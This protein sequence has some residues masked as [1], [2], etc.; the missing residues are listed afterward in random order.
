MAAVIRH[1]AASGHQLAGAG[2]VVG[3]L[4]EPE[5]IANDHIRIHAL[6][7][8]LFRKGVAEA[9]AGS[10]LSC[11]VWRE[12]DLYASAAELLRKPEQ[13]VR[14]TVA[15]FK[16]TVAGPWRAEQKAAAVAAWMILAKG[17]RPTRSIRGE[18]KTPESER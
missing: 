14:T 10:G 15:A 7:G 3:S 18:E 1:Y 8:R 9:A 13:E 4:V 17:N 6:E 11:S 12:R 16:G 5:R 2:V